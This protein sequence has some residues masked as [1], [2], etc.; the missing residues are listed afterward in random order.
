[1]VG[2][3]VTALLVPVYSGSYLWHVNLAV[4][5]YA[6]LA[7]AALAS[8]TGEV[9]RS[10]H[11]RQPVVAAAV[12]ALLVAFGAYAVNNTLISGPHAVQYRLIAG[13]RSDPSKLPVAVSKDTLVYVEDRLRIGSWSYGGGGNLLRFHYMMPKLEEKVVPAMNEVPWDLRYEWLRRPNALFVRYDDGMRWYD[14]SSEFRK[15]SLA[16]L[17]DYTGKLIEEQKWLHLIAL[18]EAS[19]REPEVRNNYLLQYHYGFALQNCGRLSDAIV[20]YSKSIDLQPAFYFSLLHRATARRQNGDLAG[21]C[22]DYRRASGAQG[23]QPHAA[24]QVKQFC[25]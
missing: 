14:G 10:L 9:A 3:I 12:T 22:S 1:M 15:A 8:F 18:L 7:G 6:V 23:A 19:F 2:W 20:A 21:A 25:R 5:G 17:S 13:L 24:D 11:I 16:K 4:C